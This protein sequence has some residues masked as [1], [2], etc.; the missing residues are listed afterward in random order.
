MI[1][2]VLR[3]L[4]LLG[5]LRVRLLV[6]W[7]LRLLRRVLV[8]RILRVLRLLRIWGLLWRLG[9]LRKR[10]GR[11]APCLWWG[12]YERVTALVAKSR[13]KRVGL[14]TLGADLRCGSA[15]LGVSVISHSNPL[16]WP[17]SRVTLVMVA[18]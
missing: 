6:L 9:M 7:V 10:D 16:S 11:L 5:L 14:A 2:R 1:L 15:T 4:R 13:G 18:A 8:L 17:L 12:A 3:L